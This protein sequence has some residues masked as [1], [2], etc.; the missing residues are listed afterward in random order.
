M[1]PEAEVEDLNG[2]DS[3]CV[4]NG[5]EFKS[6]QGQRARSQE[7]NLRSEMLR[8]EQRQVWSSAGLP[9]QALHSTGLSSQSGPC[10]KDAAKS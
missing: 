4:I 6:T 5:Q 1:E 7:A 10:V 2:K 9:C 8:W 3:G